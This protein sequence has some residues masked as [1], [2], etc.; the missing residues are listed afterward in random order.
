MSRRLVASKS[1]VDGS[2]A[3]AEARR[4]PAARLPCGPGAICPPFV[5]RHSSLGIRSLD[6]LWNL[7]LGIWS[8]EL[9]SPHITSYHHFCRTNSRSSRSSFQNMVKKQQGWIPGMLDWL[10]QCPAF[11]HRST[12]PSTRLP[13]PALLPHV[14]V[15]LA[16]EEALSR[17][18]SISRLNIP[19]AIR[20]PAFFRISTFGFE[21]FSS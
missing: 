11:I 21:P 7:E 8:F 13:Q 14:T 17:I 16:R 15:A 12:H 6:F 9:I 18:S 2:A 19:S 4:P 5:I 3:K 10:P 1:D 20:P